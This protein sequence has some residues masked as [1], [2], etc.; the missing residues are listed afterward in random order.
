MSTR[1]N[2]AFNFAFSV[3]AADPTGDHIPVAELRGALIKKLAAMSDNELLENLG[4]PFDTYEH[5]VEAE[6]VRS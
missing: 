4:A 3:D 5:S 2:H 1:Y 6:E